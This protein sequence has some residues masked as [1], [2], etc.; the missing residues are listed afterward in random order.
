[1]HVSNQQILSRKITGEIFID[2]V[3]T[4]L[5]AL[6]TSFNLKIE[7]QSQQTL[8]ISSPI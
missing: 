6:S 7:K 2:D 8:R 1:V 4:L 5:V 3:N